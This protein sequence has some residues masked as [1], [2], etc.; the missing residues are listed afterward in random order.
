MLPH[1]FIDR[2]VLAWVIAI[3]I[4]VGGGL[5]ITRL[6]AAA[7]PDIAPPQVAISAFY[8]GANADTVEHTVTQIIEQQLTGLDRL[9][10]FTSSSNSSGSAV[11]TL[12][13]EN[14]T[15]P[16]TAVLQTQNRV[17]LAEARLPSEVVVQGLSVSKMNNDFILALGV[18]APNGALTGPELNNIV[19]SQVLDPIQRI[20]GVSRADQFGSSYSMRI[21]LNPDKLRAFR[22]S[23]S[24]VLNT[25]RAQNV[26]FATGAI[27]AA[28]SAPEQQ[29]TAPVSAEGRF[30]S[31]E[32][33]EN[34]ILRTE[35]NGTS[36]RLK[37]V[38]RVELGLQD[39]GFDVR[40]DNAPV[41]GFGVNLLPG[42]NA[43]DVA[44]AVKARMN[45]LAKNFPPGVEWFVALDATTF[46]THA[47]HEVIFTL[48]AAVVLVFIVMLVFL[49]SF[50]AT[51]IPTLVVPVAL[52]GAFIGMQIFGFSI[53]QLTL[54][55]MVLAIGI[56]VDDAIV[57]IESV[58]RLMR[59]EHLSP[60]DATRKAMDQITSPI[61]AISLVLAAV[62]VP[63]AMQ[64][65]SVGVI[66][67]QFALTIA[68]SMLFSAFLALSLTPALCATL[69][70]PEH[71][72]EN[73]FFKL[74]N[75]S[76]EYAQDHFLSGVRFS[77]RHKAWWLT[78]YGVLIVVGVLVYMRVP[79]SFVPDE[80]QGYVLGQV[81]LQP[82]STIQRTREVM[83]R[84]GEKLRQS[85]A[86]LQV[87][88]V[89][90]FSFNGNDESAG[91]F[92]VRLKELEDRKESAQDVIGWAY[93]NVAFSERDASVFF[94]NLP[95]I[96]GLGQFGGFDM[97]LEDRGNKGPDALL[98]AQNLLVQKASQ[99]PVLQGVRYQGLAPS[100]RLE[101]KLDRAQAKSMGL[102][103]DDVYNAIQ[104][105]LAPVYVNDF[106][107]QGRVLRVQMQ[108]DAGFRMNEDSLN[109]FYLPTNI[110]NNAFV[111][112]GE[113][114]SDGMVPLA[115]VLRS[116]WVVAPPTVQ[117]F[118]GFAAA[119]IGGS[120]APGHS[121]GE[122]M[123]TMQ[124]IVS[125]DLPP[126][127]AID[128]AGQSLQ[129]IR[130]GAE[131][132]LLFS[133]SM[134]VVFLCL[135]ALYESWVTPIAVL[136]IVP[137]GIIGSVLAAKLTGQSDDVF[138][139][140][141][142]ITIIGLA[143]KNA[144]L[145]VEFALLAQQRGMKLYEAVME[146]GRLRLRPIMMTSFAFILGVMPLVFTSGAGAN[147]RRAI[148]IGVA[149]G[150]LSAAL[151]GVLLAPVFYVA[152]RRLTGERLEM[153]R[154]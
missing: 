67:Q 149:G 135:A 120:H 143:A 95:V 125:K 82:G 113:T 26:Q 16:D 22:M 51:L 2:P 38:A 150:M 90:G 98:A 141:G 36:V 50:R 40:L 126:G 127:F 10:Y 28:P 114:T 145:I 64:T 17:K 88:E 86:V 103:V 132:P 81:Q 106:Y 3:L 110:T 138:F 75:R 134:F 11:I 116:K 153:N 94:F 154:N 121:S 151:L 20:P 32:E 108:A 112:Q 52:M 61:I 57:V 74:F 131:A 37:D 130:A 1:Y 91:I 139:K 62:F 79:G 99:N 25:V 30:T 111:P 15:N 100:P 118:N 9:M 34:V 65:G 146:A 24:E 18:R 78:G 19:S 136:M 12:V 58:E 31:V 72:K 96:S 147:A 117:R 27:G 107:Y 76:Y 140:I 7:Y 109:R 47:I 43:L 89:S 144:I 48:C 84:V 23:A 21:W 59:E 133:L 14:G 55:G 119:S 5:A 93:Q 124:E 8:P 105:M 53:N 6:P 69:L 39:Y 123:K 68:I 80:D 87:F 104:L 152:V 54:F 41:S 35:P 60:R 83:Q 102:S 129:E 63:A 29:I 13:F 128:W 142:L 73:R 56:V 77:L 70:R 46:I 44:D 45:E 33:F 4:M 42:A 66:Y 49:Q 148:G 97:W 85:P 115:S 137:V 122:A 71:L 101:L 92:F